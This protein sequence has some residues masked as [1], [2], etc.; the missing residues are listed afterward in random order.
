MSAF[1]ALTGPVRTKDGWTLLMRRGTLGGRA[2][3]GTPVLLVPG[4]GMNSSIFTWH[5]GG[6]S[7][8][9]FLLRAGFDPWTVDLRGTRSSRPPRAGARVRL[10]DQAFLD[11]PAAAAHVLRHTGHARLHAL[12]CSLGG[13]LLYAWAG[14]SSA[15]IERWV[16]MG[17]PLEWQD[18]SALLR[19]FA[20]AGPLARW[21]PVRGSAAAARVALP[22]ARAL[23]P[24]LLSMYLNPRLTDTRD[25]GPLIA[26]VEDPHADVTASLARWMRHGRLVLGGHDVSAGLRAAAHPL[27]L[28]YATGDG[29]CPPAAA[30]AARHRTG[31]P[32]S[33]LAVSHDIERVSHV[34]LFLG[35]HV[36]TQV[37]AP[38]ANFLHGR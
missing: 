15:P 13:A 2:S 24:E 3:G 12:G 14:R 30:R 35:G 11:L 17:S 36:H 22:F 38:I 33:E 18:Q 10:A 6:P 25:H 8:M 16:T 19:L 29:V 20:A 23:V 9:E 21:V 32:V 5:P 1:R 28:V 4:F 27:L 7:L 31:G 26:T 37:Y 34:D